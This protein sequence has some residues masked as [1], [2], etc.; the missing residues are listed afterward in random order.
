[1][2]IKFERKIDSMCEITDRAVNE[3]RDEIFV[4]WN[5]LQKSGRSN[6]AVELMNSSDRGRL[7]VLLAEYKNSVHET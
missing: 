4:L 3:G 5:W 7:K 1:M 2:V 6:E